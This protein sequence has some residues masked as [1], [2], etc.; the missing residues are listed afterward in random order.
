MNVTLVL[1]VCALLAITVLLHRLSLRTVMLL[2]RL[3]YRVPTAVSNSNIW[4]RSQT[5]RSQLAD[6]Y[7]LV[8]GFIQGRITPRGFS[9]LP[10][11][12]MA[13]AAVYLAALFSG[14][15]EEV[16]EA[17]GIV[18]AD[19][20][21]NAAFGFWRVEPLIS[22]FRWVTALGSSPAIVSAAIIAT[23]FFWSQRRLN[24]IAPL[25]ITCV[26]AITTTSIGKLLIGRHRPE[27]TIDVT[28]PFSSFPSGHAT[29]AMAVYGFIAYAIARSLPNIRERFEVAYWTVV[30]I[31]LIGLSRI[32]LGV[33]YLTD[34]AGG[35]LVGGFWLLIGFTI[36]EWTRSL[37]LQQKSAQSDLGRVVTNH[38]NEPE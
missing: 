17:E 14:L 26:G 21:I 31:A 18:R 12:L 3:V 36:A 5:A 34:I 24:L 33:H 28:A 23:G 9:G 7:P 20:I 19:N 35:F 13:G 29:A 4:V 22:V 30:L 25:W 11:T 1:S 15:T 37:T 10:L 6:R 38:R 32:V 2:V 27:S 16:L 8:I